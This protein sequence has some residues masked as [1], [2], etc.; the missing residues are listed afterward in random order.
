[1]IILQKLDE[2]VISDIKKYRIFGQN[3]LI[4]F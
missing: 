2:K 3:I 1:M 4:V